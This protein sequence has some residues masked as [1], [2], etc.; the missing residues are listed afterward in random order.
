MAL[1]PGLKLCT[2]CCVYIA[3]AVCATDISIRYHMCIAH[4]TKLQYVMVTT[5]NNSCVTSYL[6]VCSGGL[7]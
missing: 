4:A 3:E 7:S 1:H 6:K 5:C 2:C